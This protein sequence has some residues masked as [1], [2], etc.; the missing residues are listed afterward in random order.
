MVDL[1]LHSASLVSSTDIIDGAW[2]AVDQGQIAAVGVGSGWPAAHRVEDLGGRTLMPG[3]MDPHTHLGSGDERSYEFMAQSFARDTV[4]CLIGGVTTI[5]TTTV[6]SRD[7]LPDS[8]RR[9]IAA[10]NGRSWCDYRISSVILHQPHVAQIAEAVGLGCLSYKFYC[11]YCLDQA[12]RMGMS[13]EGVPADLFYQ[14]CEAGRDTGA[15]VL[16]MIHAEEPHVRRLLGERFKAQGRD[17]IVAWAEHSPA[18]SE[19]VQVYLY[20]TIARE[21]GVPCYVVHISRAPTIDLIEELQRKGYPIVPETVAV[22]LSTTAQEMHRL[23][24]G[25]KAKIQPPIRFAEDQ[26]RLWQAVREGTI[27][28]LGTDTIPYT[29]RYKRSVGF[30]EARPGLNIQT[31]DT[32]PLLLSEGYHKGRV[33]LPT[34]VRICAENPARRFGAWPRKG[35]IAPGADADMIV[36]ELERE[37]PLGLHRMKGGSDYSIWEGRVARGAPVQTWLRGRL[38]VQEGELVAEQADGRYLGLGG[39]PWS[40]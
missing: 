33:D 39:A 29:S 2:V 31:I 38:M 20:A 8:I 36:V 13:R 18:W 15:P 30:W 6:L 35:R 26:E 4:D 3:M 28:C 7:P 21:L 23:G 19:A 17:D 27:Q 14:A 25:L 1:V 37:L 11:G 16:M 32:L 40:G 34:L 24:M 9:T 10:G 22:F 12:E 5:A